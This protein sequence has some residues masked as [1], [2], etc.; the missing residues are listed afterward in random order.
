MK[1]RSRLLASVACAG[2]VSLTALAG[3]ASAAS[4][5][6]PAGLSVRSVATA[7]TV[8]ANDVAICTETGIGL[9][10]EYY[11]GGPYGPGL[12]AITFPNGVQQVFVIGTD[13]AV[14]TRW[15]NSSGNWVGWTSM[16]GKCFGWVGVWGSGY[17]PI[18]GVIGSDGNTWVSERST[19]GSWS[20]W[21]PL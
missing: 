13:H 5:S 3:T 7:G 21:G 11:C 16:Y 20:K 2:A 14:W 15:T 17:S 9:G 8:T 18:L 10:G 12:F 1:R 4:A 19:D 6:T